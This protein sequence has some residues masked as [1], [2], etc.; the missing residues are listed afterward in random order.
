MPPQSDLDRRLVRS[1]A[2]NALGSGGSQ[3]I[4]FL[5]MIV[6]ARLLTP[7]AFGLVTLA[8]LP[9]IAIG[10]LQESGLTAAV[11]RYRGDVR[12]AA[13]TQLVFAF[14]SSLLLFVAA[15]AAAP[16]LARLF[17]QPELTNVFRV[18]AFTLV[19]RGAGAAPGALLEREIAFNQRAK[20]DIAGIVAQ[21]VVSVALA[22]AGFGVWS[23]VAGQ[24]VNQFSVSA[25]YWVFAP[26]R[27]SPARASWSMLRELG[28]YGRHI[29]ASNLL[30]LVND[31]ADN[32]VIGRL[33]GA[34]SVGLYNLAWRLANLPAIEIAI[35]VGRP[36]FAIYSSVQHELREFQTVFLSTLRRVLFL[37]IPVAVGIM[38]A[39]EPLVVGVFGARWRAAVVPLQILAALGWSRTLAGITAPVFQASGRPQLNYQIGLWHMAVLVG[40]LYLLVPSFGVKGVA[41]AEV[42]A[43]VASMLP[44]YF[45]ALRILDLPFRELAGSLVK[46]CLSAALVAVVLL[47]TKTAVAP[48]PELAKL[49]VLVVVG[50]AA[51]VAT[52]LTF[53]RAELQTIIG[54]FRAQPSPES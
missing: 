50:G 49:V 36:S 22:A 29:A 27:P 42:C 18:L 16:L 12:D 47:L 6:L 26:F 23:L 38:I 28:Q 20:A 5:L 3:V 33:L 31:N 11:I 1:S 7:H 45:F 48:L 40:L 32:A 15:F 39:A 54:S 46:P 13:A 37:S 21:A 25:V 2:W 51:Y 19:L 30:L 9:L 17:S 44:C 24:L 34:T 14:F 4:T 41:W 53:G 35:I 43:S 10:Y 8:S 52:M